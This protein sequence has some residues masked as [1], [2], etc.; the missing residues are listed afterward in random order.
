MPEKDARY[1]IDHLHMQAHPEGGFYAE[2]YRSEGK[3]KELDRSYS[4]GI[5]FLLLEDKFSAFHRI[6]SDEMWHFYAGS[7]IEVLVLDEHG[8]LNIHRLGNDPERGEKFQ[9]V[10]PAG[11]WFASRMADPSPA[12]YG[13]VG[14][15][16]APGFDFQ[17]F[18]MASR[19]ALS[20]QFPQHQ[21]IITA[22]TYPEA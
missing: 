13:L 17:D 8:M 4:T 18:E 2:T 15:T 11:Q 12:T 5:Y 3:I 7:P 9:L 10:V 21:Q 20:A 14:C 19:A 16:V 6:R 1:W 22:L